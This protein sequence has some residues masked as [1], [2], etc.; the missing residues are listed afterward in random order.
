[1]RDLV[2]LTVLLGCSFLSTASPWV[3]VNKIE[4][5][6]KTNEKTITFSYSWPFENEDALVNE[7]KSGCVIG[8]FFEG[9][10]L[11]NIDVSKPLTILSN[12]NCYSMK[13]IWSKW[14]EKYSTA[15]LT[16]TWTTTQSG[17]DSG[18]WAFLAFS[19]SS[20][21]NI[22]GTGTRLPGTSCASP[23]PES[24]YCS[25]DNI[26]D[27]DHGILSNENIDASS[28]T[29]RTSL[30]CNASSKVNI[31]LAYGDKIYLGS[32]S[33]DLSSEIYIE[34]NAVTSTNAV[35]VNAFSGDNDIAIESRLSS[36]GHITGG[37]YSGSGVLILDIN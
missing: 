33:S 7:C 21:N 17:A 30:N 5:D 4:T 14:V 8:A 1:M 31:Y 25:L 27:F 18:C 26:P 15:I 23:P 22:T 6:A 29:Q 3:E 16:S 28:V 11:Y 37:E 9:G 13:C 20:G 36:T 10:R 12:E 19:L 32:G 35:T 34:G 24:V 2:I